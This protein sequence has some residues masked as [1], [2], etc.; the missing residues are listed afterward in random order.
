MRKILM[1]VLMVAC[2]A[3]A[4]CGGQEKARELNICSSMGSKITAVLADG[5]AK[6]AH[7]RVNVKYLPPG[8][9]EERMAFIREN[10]IDC[11]LGGTAEEY[12]L[13]SQQ[14]MLQPYL[15]AES[16]KV[17]AEMRSKE[18]YWTS[19]YLEYIAFISNKDKLRQLG[20]YAPAVWQDLLNPLLQ[21]EIAVTDF[22]YGGASY[23]MITSIW[24]LQGREQAL[25]YAAALNRQQPVYTDSLEQTAQMV[26][27]GEKA[28]GILP[29]KYAMNLENNYRHLF[30]TVAEDANRNLLTGAA[31][32]KGS[33]NT[34]EAQEFLDYLMSDKSTELLSVNGYYYIWHVKDYPHNNLRQELLGN[35]AVPV[36]DL[37]WTAIEKNDIIRQWLSAK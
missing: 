10:K 36:D 16:Y 9:F 14:N 2:L 15:A 24:Q 6:E 7:V 22:A 3:A 19:L 27:R 29:L 35:I 8:T 18:G 26:Y 13:A 4:G 5:F 28:V 34:E 17:P 12:Y 30:A 31:V 1:M 32:I 11:W 21:N 23:G 25:E 37:S 20:L 33:A